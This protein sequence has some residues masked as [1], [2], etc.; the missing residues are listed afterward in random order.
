VH[1]EKLELKKLESYRSDIYCFL[2][3]KNNYMFLLNLA[4]PQCVYLQINVYIINEF[5]MKLFLIR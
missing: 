4:E 5:I 3:G 1:W 2:Y